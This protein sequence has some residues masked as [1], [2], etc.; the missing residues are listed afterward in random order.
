MCEIKKSTLLLTQFQ[1]TISQN[2]LTKLRVN[3]CKVLHEC[4]R[5]RYCDYLKFTPHYKPEMAM[6][7]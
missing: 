7:Q 5:A 1:C 2:R 6:V 4:M 3:F